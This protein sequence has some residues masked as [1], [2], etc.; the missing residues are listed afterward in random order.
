MQSLCGID[1]TNYFGEGEVL[2][3]RWTRAAM[4]LKSSPYQAIQAIMVAKEICLGDRQ[5]PANAFRWDKVILKS[6]S[7]QD[8]NGQG[9]TG[10]PS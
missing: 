10:G 4:G 7:Y 9:W 5:D 1:L 3:E 6:L 8:G 2:W